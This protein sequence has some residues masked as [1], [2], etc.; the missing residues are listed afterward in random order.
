MSKSGLAIHTT[1]GELGLTLIDRQ[2]QCRS[3]SWDLGRQLANQIQL[4]LNEFI[5]PLSWSELDFL[6]VAKGPGS[7]TS[8]RIG[9]VTAKTIA[10]QL[11]I[12]VY[13]ISTLEAIAWFEISKLEE[14]Q[15]IAISMPAHNEDVFGAIYQF[16]N[17]E[18]RLQLIEKEQRISKEVWQNLIDKYNTDNNPVFVT[19]NPEKIAF[20]SE[21]LLQIALL[22]ERL[23]ANNE[24]VNTWQQ[25]TAF[26]E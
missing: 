15:Y 4:Q 3:G 9:V 7:F 18:T 17:Q 21:S 14:N 16:H 1:T 13:G 26:Y 5:N 22:E 10:Q 11:D 25:L 2:D 6:A 19:Q 23:Q 8:T 24:S 12:P 20:I